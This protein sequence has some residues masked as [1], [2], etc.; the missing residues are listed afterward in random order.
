MTGNYLKN[1][2]KKTPTLILKTTFSSLNGKA[3][4][5]TGKL[6]Y[7]NSSTLTAQQCDLGIKQVVW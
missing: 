2:T 6:P 3:I 4:A 5:R 1:K 7:E